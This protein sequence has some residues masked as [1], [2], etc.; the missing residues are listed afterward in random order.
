MIKN[1]DRR[2]SKI[3][4]PIYATLLS[5][6]SILIIGF[7]VV[8]WSMGIAPKYFII[9]TTSFVAIMAIYELLVRRINIIRFLFGMRLQKKIKEG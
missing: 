8:Q 2:V 9:A 4:I 5:G 6:I 7:F 1:H 3:Q